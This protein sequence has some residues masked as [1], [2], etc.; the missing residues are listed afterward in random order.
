MK[1]ELEIN[2]IKKIEIEILQYVDK[3]CKKNNLEYF[4]DAGTLLGAIRH[5]GFIPW[6][7]DIDILMPRNDYDKLIEILKDDKK[8]P[9]YSY[10]YNQNCVYPYAKVYDSRTI[11]VEKSEEKF[12]YSTE[13]G[14][15][16]DIFPLDKLPNHKIE[17]VWHQNKVRA[18]KLLWSYLAFKHEE[19]TVKDRIC[20]F[21]VR[22]MDLGDILN[23]INMVAAKYKKRKTKYCVNI[24]TTPRPYRTT[25][26][27]F[28]EQ[29]KCVEFE[30]DLY[31]VPSGY[32]GYLTG[33]Y[34]DYMK[35]PPVEMRTSGHSFKAYWRQM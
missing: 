26:T 28:F 6:D 30:G 20:M 29:K 27:E 25:K 5:K 35:L 13:Y 16:I 24:L 32:D 23:K 3:I 4:L 10:K 8:Y 33:L 34:G 11:I 21:I 9:I 31:P 7:D 2:E 18:L 15:F 22:K 19:N 17:R 1:Q 14:I 12:I